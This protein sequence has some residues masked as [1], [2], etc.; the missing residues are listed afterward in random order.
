MPCRSLDVAAHSKK[1]FT[2]A[3]KYWESNLQDPSGGLPASRAQ[4]DGSMCRPDVPACRCTTTVTRAEPWL[5]VHGVANNPA[6]RPKGIKWDAEWKQRDPVL[7]DL[8]PTA[9]AKPVYSLQRYRDGA[10][11]PITM[12]PPDGSK[13]HASLSLWNND[14]LHARFLEAIV[15][16]QSQGRHAMRQ[17][18]WKAMQRRGVSSDA[19]SEAATTQVKAHLQVYKTT[20]AAS[21]LP[22]QDCT[23]VELQVRA[24]F[25]RMTAATASPWMCGCGCGWVLRIPLTS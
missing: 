20:L 7:A 1:M 9:D 14:G 11:T 2:A 10:A 23:T 6:E 16:L 4:H 24:D 18:V 21:G 22:P 13:R 12:P 15:E 17:S 19:G 8:S 3:R 5:S 25:V